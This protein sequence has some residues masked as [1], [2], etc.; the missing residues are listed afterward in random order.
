MRKITVIFVKIFFNNYKKVC[1]LLLYKNVSFKNY[2]LWLRGTG[3]KKDMVSSPENP[4]MNS[5]PVNRLGSERHVRI[6]VQQE[7]Q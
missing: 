3:N 1:N 2:I 5:P 4:G 6:H 7:F